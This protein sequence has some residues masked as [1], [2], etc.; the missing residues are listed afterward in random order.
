MSAQNAV[1]AFLHEH[2]VVGMCFR[3]PPRR[4]PRRGHLLIDPELKFLLTCPS[5][6]E[7]DSSERRDREDD[8]RN[9][10]VI[11]SLMVPPA[12]GLRPQSAL[13]S[14]PQ[15]PAVGLHWRRHLPLRTR[16]DSTLTQRQRVLRAW[17]SGSKAVEMLGRGYSGP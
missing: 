17:T 5:F 9:A 8:R 2:F 12:R 15:E 7:T 3:N 4:I 6:A 1:G 13:H 16:L 14:L 10:E 11:W